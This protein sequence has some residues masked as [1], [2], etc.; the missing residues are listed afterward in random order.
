MTSLLVLFSSWT[1]NYFENPPFTFLIY[2]ARSYLPPLLFDVP[3]E[4][5]VHLAYSIS[6]PPFF[7]FHAETFPGPASFLFR[8]RK[9]RLMS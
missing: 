5:K 7:S 8:V 3:S 2:M 6:A 9:T 4:G 1:V